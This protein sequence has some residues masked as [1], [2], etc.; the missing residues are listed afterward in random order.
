MALI[1]QACQLL[2]HANTTKQTSGSFRAYLA[3]SGPPNQREMCGIMKAVLKMRPSRQTTNH[4]AVV[5][6]TMKFIS[7]NDLVKL[8]PS[9]IAAGFDV[10]DTALV[11]QHT[12]M[13]SMDI[14]M[15]KFV[16][17]H[18]DC[19]CIIMDGAKIDRVMKAI[20]TG[21]FEDIAEDAATL[22][23]SCRLGSRLFS[24]A[25]DMC[26]AVSMQTLIQNTLKQLNNQP[27]T[28][29]TVAAV[30]T[31]ALDEAPR[32]FTRKLY[33]HFVSPKCAFQ[34]VETMCLH[35]SQLLG[36]RA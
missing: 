23:K 9:E 13:K 22:V 3:W 30:R 16:E 27:L 17:M 24:L 7:R 26:A 4:T 8:F 6:D 18:R 10:F 19:M 28:M 31:K 11:C 34:E 21:I 33:Y 36:I 32:K 25:W 35:K 1:P 29:K 2:F 5:I 12:G 20:A 14:S 15:E